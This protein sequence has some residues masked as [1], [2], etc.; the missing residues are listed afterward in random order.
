MGQIIR[1]DL[2][3]NIGMIPVVGMQVKGHLGTFKGKSS[4]V[5][6]T[7]IFVDYHRMA[8][9]FL[10]RINRIYMILISCSARQG[11]GCWASGIFN[12]IINWVDRLFGGIYMIILE[13]SL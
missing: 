2:H 11:I 8:V 4:C 1:K 3:D 10:D 13:C 5:M 9:I 12:E 7:K 6:A